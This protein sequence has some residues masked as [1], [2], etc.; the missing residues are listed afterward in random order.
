LRIT[1]QSCEGNRVKVTFEWT[2]ADEG[3]GIQGQWLDLSLQDNGFASGTFINAHNPPYADSTS[4]TT[5]TGGIGNLD[6]GKTHYWRINTLYPNE[7]WNP[8]ATASFTT[9]SCE[10]PPDCNM[11]YGAGV[12]SPDQ[13]NQ[14]WSQLISALPEDIANIFFY[15]IIP[16]ESGWN[17][18]SENSGCPNCWCVGL[19]QLEDNTRGAGNCSEY[20]RNHHWTCET[21]HAI[22]V[23]HRRGPCYWQGW[24]GCY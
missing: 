5:G 8:S 16:Q 21:S 24:P 13:K 22:D 20:H 12:L 23:Y 4:Y 11:G 17:A 2:R 1:S 3:P 14:V 9:I 19:Y 15:T 10:A 6:P 7:R 18:S